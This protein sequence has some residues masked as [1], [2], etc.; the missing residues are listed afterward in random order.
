VIDLTPRQILDAFD[1]ALDKAAQLAAARRLKPSPELDQ[2]V[3]PVKHIGE[4]TPREILDAFDRGLEKAARL[5][6]TNPVPLERIE[7]GHCLEP[8]PNRESASSGR[9]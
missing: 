7:I 6:K 2:K 8:Q 9:A 1:R 3:R 4:M 5:A